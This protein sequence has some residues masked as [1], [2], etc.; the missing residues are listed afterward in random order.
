[1]SYL[2]H[3]EFS[4]STPIVTNIRLAR[5]NAHINH[6]RTHCVR[7]GTLFG[8]SFTCTISQNGTDLDSA[9]ITADD[10]NAIPGS[11]IHGFFKWDFQN[12]VRLN[13]VP[14]ELHTEYTLTFT[15][16]GY[17]SDANNFFALCKDFD[18]PLVDSFGDEFNPDSPE[19]NAVSAPYGIE[20]YTFKR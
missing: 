17:T 16:S 10:I 11:H 6:L 20:I 12:K 18:R 8:G 7:V 2:L 14:E 5:V 4:D 1:M 19:D 9:T 3:D 13:K 15:S